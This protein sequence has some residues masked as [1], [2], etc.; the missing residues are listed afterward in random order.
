[1]RVLFFRDVLDGNSEKTKICWL[2]PAATREAIEAESE[3]RQPCP[4]RRAALAGGTFSQRVKMLH[5]QTMFLQCF[6]LLALAMPKKISFFA[7]KDTGERWGEGW[8]ARRR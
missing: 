8:V 6:I 2:S 1:M 7:E 4:A 5:N 3:S